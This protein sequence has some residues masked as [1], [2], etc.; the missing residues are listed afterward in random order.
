MQTKNDTQTND[1]HTKTELQNATYTLKIIQKQGTQ[2]K[3]YIGPTQTKS[4]PFDQ[5]LMWF[6]SLSI[7]VFVTYF[8]YRLLFL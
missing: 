1:K 6:F 3:T 7:F 8:V 2:S 5:K 4:A